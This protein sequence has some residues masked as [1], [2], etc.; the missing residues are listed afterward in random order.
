MLEGGVSS[1]VCG[2]SLIESQ[3]TVEI[4]HLGGLSDPDSFQ[5]MPLP[6]VGHRLHNLNSTTGRGTSWKLSGSKRPPRRVISTVS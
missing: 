3:P 4:A 6:I 5:D 1:S 2:S